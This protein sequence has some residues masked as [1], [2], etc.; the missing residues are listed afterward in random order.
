[1]LMILNKQR[2]KH[3]QEP[4]FVSEA[5]QFIQQARIL[6]QKRAEESGPNIRKQDK[7]IKL[8]KLSTMSRGISK[9]LEKFDTK[10]IDN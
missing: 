10:Q 3:L 6:S 7:I 5:D 4:N 1:M 8:K 2:A 9:F